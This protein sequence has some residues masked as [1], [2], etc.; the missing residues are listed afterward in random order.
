MTQDRRHFAFMHVFALMHIYSI[1]EIFHPKLKH[2]TGSIKQKVVH[3][4]G[5]EDGM[6]SKLDNLSLVGLP[7]RSCRNY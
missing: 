7:H 2:I 4:C 3:V 5:N 6:E 1:F